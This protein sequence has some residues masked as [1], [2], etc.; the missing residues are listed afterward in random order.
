NS[1]RAA[2]IFALLYFA[3]SIIAMLDPVVDAVWAIAQRRIHIVA[4]RIDNRS[5]QIIASNIAVRERGSTDVASY[6]IVAR[7]RLASSD[8]LLLSTGSIGKL[9]GAVLVG[10]AT[11]WITIVIVLN[12]LYHAT[13]VVENRAIFFARWI[14]LLIRLA[15]VIVLSSGDEHCIAAS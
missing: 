2:L 1:D 6:L 5:Q 4:I 9:D 8:C 7:T 15:V 3:L 11:G 14:D 13:G 12:R 10:Y